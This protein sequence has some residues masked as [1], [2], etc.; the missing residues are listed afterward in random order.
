MHHLEQPSR[1]RRS[2]RNAAE[3]YERLKRQ[4]CHNAALY[5]NQGN[6]WLLAG[7]LPRAILAYRQALRLAPNDT[8]LRH[9]L[10]YARN[11]VV[12]S[13]PNQFARPPAA[14]WSWWFPR[15]GLSVYLVLA[16]A[17]YCMAWLCFTRWWMSRRRSLWMA[18]GALSTTALLLAVAFVVEY[19]QTEQDSLHPLVVVAENGV[20]L[21]K[22]NGE[23]Y[24]RFETA[25]NQGV[26]ARLLFDRD[27][28]LQI[29]L[30]GGVVGWV[31]RE[32]VIV[33]V[34]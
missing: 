17:P 7:E 5:R 12:S 26:E 9:S 4:G 16:F 2:F 27:N 23:S 19:R 18:G 34:P 30:A 8:S 24:P 28:W 14:S 25:L 3:A 32:Y 1:A 6:A 13:P 11:Q 22:G 31:R 15:L 29:E 10:G 21:Y 33:D 20:P